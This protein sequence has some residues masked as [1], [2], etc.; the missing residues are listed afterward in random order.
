MQDKT[1]RAPP[2]HLFYSISGPTQT[3][4]RF[5]RVCS[6]SARPSCIRR[7]VRELA[8]R[9]PDSGE[10]TEVCFCFF[11]IAKWARGWFFDAVGLFEEADLPTRMYDGFRGS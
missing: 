1:T 11:F 2:P 9:G 10:I 4:E 6:L 3:G 5:V 8:G 7:V